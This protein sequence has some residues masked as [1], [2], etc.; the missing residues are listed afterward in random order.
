MRRVPSDIRRRPYIGHVVHGDRTAAL[1][2]AMELQLEVRYFVKD[3]LVLDN[4]GAVMLGMFKERLKE[5]TEYRSHRWTNTQWM[6]ECQRQNHYRP[7][8]ETA[9]KYAI[10]SIGSSLTR[11]YESSTSAG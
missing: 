7:L 4:T 9:N 11:T 10:I 2:A 1:Q 6:K 5:L 3:G 8:L